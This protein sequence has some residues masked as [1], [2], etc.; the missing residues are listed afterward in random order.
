[1]T[2]NEALAALEAVGFPDVMC[3]AERA[4]FENLLILRAYV[5]GW[6]G[7][8]LCQPASSVLVAFR[9]MRRERVSS[10]DRA[11]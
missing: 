9:Q 5:R 10:V 11:S 6:T 8:P 7:D 1:M 2:E 4:H 3:D